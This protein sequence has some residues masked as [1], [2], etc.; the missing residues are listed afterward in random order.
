MRQD[1]E[2]KV[3][4]STCTHRGE[5]RGLSQET[6]CSSCKHQRYLKDYYKPKDESEPYG[7]DR[8]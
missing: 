1:N 3:D 6:Y 2:S 7:W 4:C 5:V 8:L